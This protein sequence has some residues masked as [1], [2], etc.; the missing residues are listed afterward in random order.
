METLNNTTFI[1]QGGFLREAPSKENVCSTNTSA[2]SLDTILGGC[3][4][5]NIG[6]F[7]M[8][9]KIVVVL[10]LGTTENLE[11]GLILQK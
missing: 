1:I 3:K 9:P 7:K 4:I 10:V 11:F 5:L 2:R 8:Q 6:I